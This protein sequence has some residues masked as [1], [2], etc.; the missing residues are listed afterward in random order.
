MPIVRYTEVASRMRSLVTYQM[1]LFIALPD[2]MEK[3][4]QS[5]SIP[6]TMFIIISVENIP[7]MLVESM[8]P[9]SINNPRTRD[10]PTK[11]S[12]QGKIMAINEII[13]SGTI[14]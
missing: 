5:I 8:I 3:H 9:P 6:R 4:P 2:E 10:I 12:S 1:G 11:S 7:N 14:L 13:L